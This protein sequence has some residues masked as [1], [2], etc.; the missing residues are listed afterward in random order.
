MA[1][2]VLLVV[3]CTALPVHL[4]LIGANRLGASAAAIIATLEP[5]VALILAMLLLGELLTPI[6][7]V[8]A[9]AV[10]GAAVAASAGSEPR[11][12]AELARPSP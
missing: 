11:D 5:V 3:G 8:G 6:Q 10:V 7:A 9:L 2:A 4:Q 1:L 12:P